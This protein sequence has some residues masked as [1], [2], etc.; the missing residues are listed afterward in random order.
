MNQRQRL[1][2]AGAIVFVLLA[3]APAYYA[4]SLPWH[5][6]TDFDIIGFLWIMQNLPRLFAWVLTCG[7]AFGA[8][9]MSLKAWWDV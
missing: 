5:A 3:I 4:I 6:K 8:V 9:V 2:R 7:F 1:F